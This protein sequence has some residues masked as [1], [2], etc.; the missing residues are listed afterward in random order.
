MV[1]IGT[2]R[3]EAMLTRRCCTLSRCYDQMTCR[4][5]RQ[6]FYLSN[7]LATIHGVLILG[8][9]RELQHAQ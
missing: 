8:W 5:S 9:S 1:T 2:K 7:T 6:C 3:L 4:A